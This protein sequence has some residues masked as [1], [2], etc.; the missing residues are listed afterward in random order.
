M[1]INILSTRNTCDVVGLTVIV[2]NVLNDLHVNVLSS[3][4]S[5]TPSVPK[6][7]SGIQSACANPKTSNTDYKGIA[8]DAVSQIKGGSAKRG[9][10]GNVVNANVG[11]ELHM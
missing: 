10:Y 7:A 9:E 8:A 2:Q 3:K 4:R 1:N 5:G 11:K 6:I